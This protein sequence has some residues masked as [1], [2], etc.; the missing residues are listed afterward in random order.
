MLGVNIRRI[1]LDHHLSQAEFGRIIH[2]FQSAVSQWEKDITR[3]DTDTLRAIALAFNVSIDTIMGDEPL[4]S[5]REL[6][7]TPNAAPLSAAEEKIILD[8]RSMNKTGQMR[9][10]TIMDDYLLVYSDRCDT[11]ETDPV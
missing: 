11:E 10:R 1:R 3:P 5:F 7:L 8:Y 2:V 9:I 6:T 4:P